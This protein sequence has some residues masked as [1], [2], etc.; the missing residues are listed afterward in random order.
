MLLVLLNQ[1]YIMKQRWWIVNVMNNRKQFN[2]GDRVAVH[3]ENDIE[4]MRLN[5]DVFIN[6]DIDKDD[7]S[8]YARYRK[9]YIVDIKRHWFY[10]FK[11]MYLL[12]DGNWYPLKHLIPVVKWN[13]RDEEMRRKVE[14]AK[15]AL[16]TFSVN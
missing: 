9:M 13:Q 15:E 6:G 16:S 11:E 14:E 8:R 12:S 4:V 1:E 5:I 3:Y 2:I 7:K 10:L